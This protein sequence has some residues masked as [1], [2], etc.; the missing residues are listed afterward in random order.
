MYEFREADVAPA[1]AHLLE[2]LDSRGWTQ[3]EFANIL[4]RPVQFISEIIHGKKE[5]TRES[6]AQIGAAFNM[7]AEYWLKLQDSFHLAKQRE[8]GD[9]VARLELVRRRAQLRKMFPIPV[10]AQRGL[11]HPTDPDQQERDVLRLYRISSIDDQR[12]FGLAARRSNVA[13]PL[14]QLQEAWSVCVRDKAEIRPVSN[15]NEAAFLHLASALPKR[16]R[17]ARDFAALPDE[18]ADVGVKL[19]HIDA[20]PSSKLDGCAFFDGATPV[21]GLSGRGRRMDKVFFTLLHEAAHV[22]LGHVGS[23]PI[24]DEGNPE[25]VPDADI[26]KEADDLAAKWS[27]GDGLPEAPARVNEAWIEATAKEYGLHPLVVIGR[28]QHDGILSWRTSLVREAPTV[29]RELQSWS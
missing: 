28:L 7:S 24:V 16:L 11:V 25:N 27:F 10:L 3:A 13:E 19:V 18:F 20:F 5:I 14:S 6:A 26:E 21:I 17:S 29:T 4:G 1:G 8:D 9:A 15:Y 22:L 12:T 2:E 23:A